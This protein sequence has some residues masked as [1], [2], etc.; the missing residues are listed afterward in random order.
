MKLVFLGTGGSYPTPH[1][2]VP[3]TALKYEGEVL[4]FDCGEGSQRQLMR[5]SLSFM[6]VSKIFIT[7][8]HGDHFLGIPGLVQS[9]NMNDR[10]DRLDIYGPEGT[11]SLLKDLLSKGYFGA[12]F[13][14]HLTELK[15]QARLDLDD[16]QISTFQTDHDVPSFGYSFK[17]RDKKGRFDRKKALELGVPEG[18]LFS[19]I[20][21]GE[22]VEVD[23]KIIHPEQIV[24]PP[25]RGKKIVYTGD[26]RPSQN[27]IEASNR[28]NVLI[29]DSTL[30]SSMSD[31]AMERG[32]SSTVMAADLARK[33]GV[34]R[35][36]LTHISPRYTD[37]KELE[38]EAREVF[39]ESTVPD[40]L[41]EIEL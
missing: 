1:R 9:M 19:R 4:L 5:S 31:R 41:F 23:G 17:E 39:E 16:Y 7:H 28:A 35:L 33:V 29:H 21:D 36:F 10:E 32:H 18:P 30:D 22:P 40:D 26:T 20:H 25:R 8:F 34:E 12:G 3:C 13:P 37:G 38:D 11:V 27:T 15:P 24:G 14:I 6:Q 2:N